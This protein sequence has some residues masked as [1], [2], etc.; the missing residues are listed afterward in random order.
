M[1]SSASGST[2][3]PV[4]INCEGSPRLSTSLRMES[5]M[6]GNACHS[7]IKRGVVPSKRDLGLISIIWV[8]CFSTDA[9]PRSS[10]LFASCFA[11]VV[12]PH[13]LGPSMRTAPFPRTLRSRSLSAIRC[14]YFAITF[15]FWPQRYS[16]YVK[17]TRKSKTFRSFVAHSF[18]RL[19][20]ICSVICRK[21]IR[22]F[23]NIQLRISR[24]LRIVPGLT[25]DAE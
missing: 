3:D 16:F 15:P 25:V 4:S 24:I 1:V 20:H 11:V 8:L 5:Q 10:T 14:L 19:W 6:G 17:Q 2:D 18:G 23:V 9:S 7:S 12:L 13:H 22:L 21:L